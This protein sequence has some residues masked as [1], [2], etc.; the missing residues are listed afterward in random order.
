MKIKEKITKKSVWNKGISQGQKKAFTP[1]QVKMI[2]DNL[3]AGKNESLKDLRDLC[4]FCTAVDTLL[5]ASDLLKLRVEDVQNPDRSL[6]IQFYIQQQKTSRLHKVEISDKTRLLLREWLDRG[7]RR[8]SD[9]I[10]TR[11]LRRRGYDHEPLSWDQYRLIVK[12]WAQVAR[13]KDV[14]EYSTHSLRRTQAVELWLRTQ[15]AKLVMELLGQKSLS[16]TG[17]YLGLNQDEA[18]N[19]ARDHRLL[20]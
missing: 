16:A 14:M 12:R 13:V 7:H 8:E 19:I 2:Y 1:A 4:L 10:F 20:G 5:R 9:F 15:N 11:V 18:L 6:K 3:L 17:Y